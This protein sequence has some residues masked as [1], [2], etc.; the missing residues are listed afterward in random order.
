MLG[1]VLA[2]WC[3]LAAVA[4]S[5]WGGGVECADA[6]S[7]EPTREVLQL[8]NDIMTDYIKRL[9]A[10]LRNRSQT[11]DPALTKAYVE[12]R[13]KEYEYHVR[14]MD[15]AIHALDTQRVASNIVL[16]LVVLV[17]VSGI[18]FAG[19]QLWKSVVVAGVQSSTDLEISAGKVR[20]TSSVVGLVVLTLSLAF[21]YIYSKE[22]YHVSWVGPAAS[23]PQDPPKK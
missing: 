18:G 3:I 17:V 1:L 22:I 20:V 5:L 14:V 8:Q 4:A 16:I 2:R 12:A 6:Q 9:E 21:L 15:A 11:T 13:K 23:E 7:N 19:F 10:G